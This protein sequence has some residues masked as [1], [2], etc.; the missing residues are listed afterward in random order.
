MHTLSEM[1]SSTPAQRNDNNNDDD[2]D[3][4]FYQSCL[5]YKR[6]SIVF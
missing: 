4:N 6:V 5:F 1:S 2:E 3:E